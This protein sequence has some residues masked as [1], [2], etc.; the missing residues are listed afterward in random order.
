MRLVAQRWVFIAVYM[1]SSFAGGFTACVIPPR[2]GH[3]WG[4]TAAA[5]ETLDKSNAQLVCDWDVKSRLLDCETMDEY[6]ERKR[7]ES[8]TG[9]KVPKRR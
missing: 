3:V 1:A 5:K 2:D 7:W 8:L 4:V 6:I 9:E